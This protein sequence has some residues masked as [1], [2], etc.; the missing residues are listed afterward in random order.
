MPAVAASAA[1]TYARNTTARPQPRSPASRS[2]VTVMH[3]TLEDT[4]LFTGLRRLDGR[5][6]AVTGRLTEEHHVIAGLLSRVD[7]ALVALVTDPVRG[8]PAVRAAVDLLTDALLSHLSYEEHQILEPLAR[9]GPA[10]YG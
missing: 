6:T 9:L 3:H 8:M 4:S 10:I 1:L 7:A 5:L 2:G